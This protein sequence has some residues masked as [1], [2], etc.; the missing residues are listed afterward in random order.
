[1][2]RDEATAS[3]KPFYMFLHMTM[4]KARICCKYNF[5]P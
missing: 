2:A 5:D 3:T 4:L 1:M